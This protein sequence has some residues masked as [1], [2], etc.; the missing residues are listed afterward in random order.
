M[1]EDLEKR[2]TNLE[3]MN[4]DLEKRNKALGIDLNKARL[5]HQALNENTLKHTNYL[6]NE[7]FRSPCTPFDD[8]FE[9]NFQKSSGTH[10][11]EFPYVS[12][13]R[14]SKDDHFL[15]FTPQYF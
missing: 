7:P 13:G 8:E 4:E 6:I 9:E 2:N 10:S 1:N 14:N 3:K 11:I 5:Q 12:S 15:S